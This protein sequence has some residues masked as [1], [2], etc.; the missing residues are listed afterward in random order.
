MKV[1]GTV[2]G[3][4]TG[5]TI[6]VKA[7]LGPLAHARTV[8]HELAHELLHQDRF[9]EIRTYKVAAK[10]A[11]RP[12]RPIREA[13]ADAAAFVVMEA[14]GYRIDT[15]TYLAWMGA[16]GADIYGSLK[17]I[18]AAARGLL[19]AIEGGAKRP[20]IPWWGAETHHTQS[21]HLNPPSAENNNPHR[22]ARPPV[23]PSRSRR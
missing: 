12:P 8:V 4:S 5:G 23:T 3:L 17:R 11:V 10:R 15:P 7:G 19:G 6:Y 2:V 20:V 9:L 22:T 14:L 21:T 18:H 1:P 16:D 13:E